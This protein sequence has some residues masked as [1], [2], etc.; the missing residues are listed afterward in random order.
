MS[1]ISNIKKGLVKMFT[2][3]DSKNVMSV[4]EFEEIRKTEEN[5]LM[6]DVRNPDEL[7]GPLGKID[8]VINI[9]L[10]QL[11][12]RLEE[13]EQYRSGKIAVI[14]HSGG[15]SMM[16]TKMLVGQGFDAVNVMGGMIQYRAA[17]RN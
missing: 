4:T 13:I 6:L 16:A 7:A 3:L 11:V 5:L 14:C 12:S 1:L 15:R 17:C 10:N 8:N 9:P 2:G